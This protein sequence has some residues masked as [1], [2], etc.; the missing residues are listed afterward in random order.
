M[1]LPGPEDLDALAR[2]SSERG[3]CSLTLGILVVQKKEDTVLPSHPVQLSRAWEAH[4]GWRMIVP[5]RLGH[6]RSS[7]LGRSTVITA[8]S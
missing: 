5:P 4:L 1:T 7:H 8:L 3:E 2:I 6:I